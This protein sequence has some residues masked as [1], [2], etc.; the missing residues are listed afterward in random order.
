MNRMAIFR[1]QKRGGR[2]RSAEDRSRHRRLV[3]EVIKRNLGNIIAE[4][5]I[6][7]QNQGKIFKIPIRGLKEYQ[8]IYGENRPGVA[9]GK[10][11]EK[12]GQRISG[13]GDKRMSGSG[14]GAGQGE[15]DEIYETEITLEE[16]V[17]YLF[18]DLNLPFMERKKLSLLETES[19][20][21]RWGIQRKGIPPRLAKK[22]TMVERIKRMKSGQRIESGQDEIIDPPERFPFSENDLRYQR[23]KEQLRPESNAVVICIMDNSG[24]MYLSK[25]FIARSFFFLLYQFVRY[26]YVNVELVFI[27]HT[28]V[29]KEVNE[30]DFFHRGESGGT[31]ISSGYEKALEIIAERFSPAIWNIYA[32]HCSDGDNWPEDNDKALLKA[33]ELCGICNLF[34]YGEIVSTWTPGE[35]MSEIFE[36]EIKVRNFLSVKMGS[37]EDIWPAFKKLLT[38]AEKEGRDEPRI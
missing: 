4:E 21:K 23:L 10:G 37:K 5:S 22:R 2:D 28:T 35:T 30:D 3:E 24:S 6:I 26:R 7:G 11:E 1:E 29:A 18:E 31:M 8:F 12:R 13:V 17:N 25:K 32:F 38:I 20:N 36:K 14:D 19:S 33:G 27:N 15:G 16:L 9:A 34:G